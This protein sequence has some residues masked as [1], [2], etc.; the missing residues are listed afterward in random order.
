M[1]GKPSST[2]AFEKRFNPLLSRT[3][4]EFIEALVDVPPKPAEME[5]ILLQN[6]GR[7]EPVR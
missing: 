1:S 3:K 2:I 5:R 4:A 7:S 6:Q